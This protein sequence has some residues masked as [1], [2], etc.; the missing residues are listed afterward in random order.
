MN[1]EKTIFTTDKEEVRGVA[2]ISLLG[3]TIVAAFGIFF[4]I[5]FLGSSLRGE[6]INPLEAAILCLLLLGIASLP[7]VAVG[8]GT[9]FRYQLPYGKVFVLIV[10]IVIGMFVTES[11]L[12]F[13][14][15][16]LAHSRI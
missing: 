11:A 7:I 13:M 14:A 2:A 16:E 10:V 6:V 4:A 15:D 5:H 3:L 9:N 12:E 1:K 8:I